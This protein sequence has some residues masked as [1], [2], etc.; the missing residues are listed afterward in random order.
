MT[1]FDSH[2][3]LPSVLV[4]TGDS[5]STAHGTGTVLI[6]QFSRYPL[7]R[8]LNVHFEKH[9]EPTFPLSKQVRRND[10]I[11]LSYLVR[12]PIRST[13]RVI[14]KKYAARAIEI[15]ELSNYLRRIQFIPDVVYAN[16]FYGYHVQVVEHLLR[17]I[18]PKPAVILYFQDYGLGLNLTQEDPLIEQV[19]KIEKGVTEIWA[20]SQALAIRLQ[21]AL[22]RRVEVVSNL[23]MESPRHSKAEHR[24]YSKEFKVCLFG[25]VYTHQRPILQLLIDTW[26]CLS[27]RLGGLQPIDW[28]CHPEQFAEIRNCYAEPWSNLRYGGF[29]S[30][31]QLQATLATYDLA[32]VPFNTNDYP[33]SYYDA[34]SFPSRMTELCAIGL[35]VF[36]IAG[37][38]T[39]LAEFIN[40]QAIGIVACGRASELANEL[41][42]FILDKDLRERYG[43]NARKLAA[44]KWELGAHQDWLYSKFR[45][46]AHQAQAKAAPR[47]A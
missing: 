47:R 43:A 5:V 13:L 25:R 29:L 19:L 26:D 8:V 16:C 35:P 11:T 2:D 42:R 21:A 46:L 14:W 22:G 39:E 45:L 9:G 40:R 12:Y 18:K 27:D 34:F 33:N 24:A 41:E 32:I 38:H 1:I 31:E 23:Q 44:E 4:I 7:Q 6:R 15:R 20:L 28:Y 37:Q 36:A 30:G 3:E 17:K 10:K